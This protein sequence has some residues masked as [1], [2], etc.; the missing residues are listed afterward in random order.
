MDNEIYGIIYAKRGFDCLKQC[1]FVEECIID[2]Y[3]NDFLF[4]KKEFSN[5]NDYYIYLNGKIVTDACYF[6]YIFSNEELKIIGKNIKDI[7]Y[8]CYHKDDLTN[9]N[10][11]NVSEA[12]RS[13][14]ELELSNISKMHALLENFTFVKTYDDLCEALEKFNDEFSDEN[15]NIF[16]SYFIVHNYKLIKSIAIEFLI[17]NFQKEGFLFKD[18][19]VEF[20]IEVAEQIINNEIFKKKNKAKIGKYKT[21]LTYFKTGDYS[22]YIHGKFNVS[23]QKYY[24]YKEFLHDGLVIITIER[25]FLTFNEMIIYLNNDLSNINLANALILDKDFSKYKRNDNTVLPNSHLITKYEIKKEF[26]CNSF[27]VNQ[28]WLDNNNNIILDYVHEFSYFC[29]FY[30]F[31]KGDLSFGDFIMCDG[32]DNIIN[33]PNVNYENIKVQS[34]YAEKMNIKINKINYNFSDINDLFAINSNDIKENIL[35]EHSNDEIFDKNISYVTDIHLMHKIL[36][37][38]CTTNEDVTYLITNIINNLNNESS[39]I[40]IIGGD[41]S[42]E[43]T[44]YEK[45]ILKYSQT[46]KSQTFITLGNHELWS[47]PNLSLNE[48]VQKYKKLIKNNGM[49]LVH[50][51]LFLLINDKVEEITEEELIKLSTLEIRVKAREASLIIFGGIGFSGR[52]EEINA[53]KGIYKNVISRQQEIKLS[54]EF[55]DLYEKVISSLYD[56]NIIIITH[57]PLKDWAE[58]YNPIK[59][60]V[61]VNGHNH[62]NYFYD[63][64]ITRVYSDNQIGYSSNIVNFK[65]LS[66]SCNYDWF[67]IFNDGIHEIHKEDYYKFYRCLNLKLTFNQEFPKIYMLKKENTYLFLVQ[68]KNNKLCILNGGKIKSLSCQDIKYYYDNLSIYSNSINAFLSDYGNFE[69]DVSK[70]IKKIGGSGFIHG[71]II[72]IDFYNHLY[73]NPFDKKITPYNAVSTEELNVYGSLSSLLKDKR[74]DLFRNYL[75]F[76]NNESLISYNENLVVQSK[77]FIS[78]GEGIYKISRI[79][80]SLQYATKYNIIRIWNDQMIKEE[81][82]ENGKVF[83]KEITK[84]E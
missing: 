68:T 77:S 30:Y 74:D 55:N 75:N 54:Q 34:K 7:N 83:F 28:L 76:N 51:N 16:F 5:F 46:V 10:F 21:Y 67:S 6:G 18:I 60:F 27:F 57:M 63:N 39:A 56:K 47:F 79:I 72:D 3:T 59:H 71:C 2:E 53:D 40:N 4:K 48:I 37:E 82:L 19:L 20:G 26:K 81:L 31:L 65:H 25:I 41:I 13:Q 8:E 14:Y 69:K 64:G 17:K 24:V 11:D 23:D 61:Y 22:T 73:L 33:L 80:C 45:F 49:F 78:N 66:V 12:Y 84:L 32:I 1:F 15:D 50:N 36:N 29:D 52:N 43:Y 9:Y 62:R 35:I 58:N 38:K 70:E 42:S 44:I